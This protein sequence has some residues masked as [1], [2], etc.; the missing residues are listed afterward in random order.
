MSPRLLLLPGLEGTGRLFAPLQAALAD[1]I[2]IVVIAYRDE[3][4]LEEYVQSVANRMADTNNVLIAESFSGPIALALLSRYPSRIRC[5]V[6]CATFAVSPLRTFCRAARFMPTW[7]FRTSPLRR[8]LIRL[9]ALNGETHQPIVQEIM[10]VTGS[11]PA[12][13]TKSRLAVLSQIDLRP[14]L[15]SI[16]LPVLYLQASRDRV[17]SRRL[18]RQVIEG[19]P[20]VEARVIDGPHMLAQTRAREC[21]NAIK[22]FLL[23]IQ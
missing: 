11:V 19:L 22:E 8:A 10:A 16:H 23:T 15:A 2:E 21:A 17:V 5:A 1:D 18:S 9:F 6:L 4:T 20:R 14:V 7:G 3:Q 13:V 12:A